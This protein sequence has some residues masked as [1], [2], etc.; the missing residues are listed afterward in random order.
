MAEEKEPELP[1]LAPAGLTLLF[2]FG[3]LMWYDVPR[4]NGR[5]FDPY[6]Q[7]QVPHIKEY[8]YESWLWQDPFGVDLDSNTQKN[9]Y[10]I[11]FNDS[12][13]KRS[14]VHYKVLKKMDLEPFDQKEESEDQCEYQ[15]NKILN[16]SSNDPR[17]PGISESG[18]KILAPLLKVQP[19]SLENKE[20]RTRQRYAVI[21]GLIESGYSPS[22][23][24]RLHFCSSKKNSSNKGP[25]QKSS[26]NNKYDVRWEHYF[27][28]SR[29]KPDIIVAWMNSEMFETDDD[30]PKLSLDKLAFVP[31]NLLIPGKEDKNNFY[32]F[33]LNNIFG[34]DHFEE[35]TEKHK[36]IAFIKPAG[37]GS[38]ELTEKLIGKLTEELIKRQH[39]KGPSDL[40]VI[41]EQDSENVR[42]FS[43]SFR[44]TLC[45]S[46]AKDIKDIEGKQIMNEPIV[47]CAH[48]SEIKNVFYLKGLDAH[49]TIQKQDKNEGEQATNKRAERLSV[50]DMDNPTTLAVGPRQLDYFHRLA[51]DIRNPHKKINLEKRDSGI[52]A[53]GIFGS[54]IY[55]K[56]L[57][58]GALRAEMPNMLVFTTDLDAQMLHAKHWP[59]TRNLVVASNFDLL[60]NEKYQSTFPSFRDSQQ[61]SIFYRTISIVKGDVEKSEI[62][63][64]QIFEIG[65][66]VLVR[67]SSI[68]EKYEDLNYYHPPDDA[69][70]QIKT[71]LTLLTWI[72]FSL[73][74]FYWRIRA[75]S[76]R[77]SIYLSFGTL[78][79]FAI[80][81]FSATKEVGEP[82]SFTDGTS[83][84]P[85]IF[86]QIIAIFLALAFFYKARKELEENFDSLN[87]DENAP[88]FKIDLKEPEHLHIFKL[89]EKGKPLPEK[90]KL[91]LPEKIKPL[92]PRLITWVEFFQPK[93]RL[94][95][96]I[97]I[98]T[99]IAYTVNDAYPADFRFWPCLIG[100]VLLTIFFL[101]RTWTKKDEDNFNFDS[102][103]DWVEKDNLQVTTKDDNSLWREYCKYNRADHCVNRAVAIWLFFAIIETILIY[104]LP[105]WPWPCRG[106]T[107]T[108]VYWTG[109][110][111]FVVIMVL[112]FFILDAVKLSFVWIRKLRTQHPLL[113]DKNGEENLN[114]FNNP[115]ESLEKVIEVVAE[116]TRVVDELIYYPMLCI[117][118]MLFAKITYFDNQD[119]PLSKAITFA[120]SISLLFFSGFMIRK[121]AKQ[122]KLSV[123]ERI[124][125]LPKSNKSD[126]IKADATIEKINSI[127][128]GA[129][130]PMFEQPVMRALLI[131]L[132]S[133]SLFASK[134]LEFFG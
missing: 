37:T 126:R 9:E 57:I 86:I 38:K 44:K 132:A 22:E 16:A 78:V 36:N 30:D 88:F 80:A 96:I 116:R 17:M 8:A 66:D 61:T 123:L 28:Q 52:K 20:L 97:F 122:L 93:L 112:L 49:Q 1:D 113:D 64:P 131:I 69:A 35:I 121:V 87:V 21:A 27:H 117:M 71:E 48:E 95:I 56:L 111:S 63:S 89:P 62:T 53:V 114:A 105:P 107:C 58:L 65:R 72:I 90:V 32:L 102:I 39:I 92:L 68:Q 115:L 13:E 33:D 51:E 43:H 129:F 10:Y 40:M 24:D 81:L 100:L 7:N 6:T 47:P 59:S 125:K 84:W 42:N 74:A 73:I 75:H 101:T 11:E 67:L 46:L 82:L 23:S 91:L 94:P 45:N 5:P 70:K 120:V 130:Q 25:D 55:D 106:P 19:N 104:I 99:A 3:L 60:L 34:R 2:I 134:Y 18:V 77:L 98:S 79:I 110:T 124:K 83:L 41:T 118:L 29:D 108:W 26:S 50:V 85:T 133:I 15:L 54:D 128:E 31:G 119:F 109:V 14:N 127:C 103:K 12:L 76:D 4:E